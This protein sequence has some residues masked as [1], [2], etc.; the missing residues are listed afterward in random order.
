VT[1]LAY[2]LE[3][4]IGHYLS[5]HF[6]ELMA[7]AEYVPHRAVAFVD[8]EGMLIGAVGLSWLNPWD[9][10]LSIHLDKPTC[11]SRAILKELFSHCFDTLKAVRLTCHVRKSNKRAR[12]F[13]ERLGWKNEGCKRKGFDGKRDAIVYGLV[14]NECRW[15]GKGDVK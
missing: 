15:L 2:G 5:A 10:E 8:D 11:L 1:R 7:A 6:P 13:V 9:A 14:K 12:R 3:E 4:H